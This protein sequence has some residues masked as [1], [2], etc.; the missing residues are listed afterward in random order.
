MLYF[1]GLIRREEHIAQNPHLPPNS[2]AINRSS[3][4]L[5]SIPTPTIL[6]EMRARRSVKV[7][8]KGNEQHSRDYSDL[9]N[10][11]FKV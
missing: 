8:L 5:S 4:R 3:G 6:S 2:H 1:Q 9:I 7:Q 11:C 10:E